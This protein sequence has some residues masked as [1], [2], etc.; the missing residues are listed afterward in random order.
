MIEYKEGDVVL[1]GNGMVAKVWEA[2]GLITV[3]VYDGVCSVEVF[4]STDQGLVR[5]GTGEYSPSADSPSCPFNSIAVRLRALLKKP[6]PVQR[7]SK[8]S[9]SSSSKIR[10]S[11]RR[12][13]RR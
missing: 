11:T 10:S 12:S 8:K 9:N 6:L 7:A 3:V 5:E 13:S 4:R 2:E 1:N